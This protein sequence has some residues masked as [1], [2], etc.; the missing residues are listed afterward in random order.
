MLINSFAI[1]SGVRALNSVM[2]YWISSIKC[3]YKCAIKNQHHCFQSIWIWSWCYMCAVFL[4]CVPKNCWVPT[5]LL[6]ANLNR[7]CH[8]YHCWNANTQ[9]SPFIEW[10][11]FIQFIFNQLKT[12]CLQT[13]FNLTKS[14]GFVPNVFGIKYVRSNLY[15]FHSTFHCIFIDTI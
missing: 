4:I 14:P 1:F 6:I 13:Q 11:K 10:N 15:A 2:V 12:V 9:N 7:R 8:W 3:N 5:L